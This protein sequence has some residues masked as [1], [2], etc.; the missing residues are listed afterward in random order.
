MCEAAS[1]DIIGNAQSLPPPGKLMELP[2]VKASK[3]PNPCHLYNDELT[4]TAG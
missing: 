4:T 1:L 3:S 2:I